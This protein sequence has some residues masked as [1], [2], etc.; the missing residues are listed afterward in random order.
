MEGFGLPILEA[1]SHATPVVASSATATAEVVEDAGLLAD[2]EPPDSI[3]QSINKILNNS[4]LALELGE[5]GLVRAEKFTWK[6]TALM[7][8]EIYVDACYTHLNEL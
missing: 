5:K 2:P 6:E 3:A 7:T 8:A 4:E 1:M